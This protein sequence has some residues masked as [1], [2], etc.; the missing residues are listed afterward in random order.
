M[1]DAR[2]LRRARVA[3][4]VGVTAIAFAAI[5]FRRT[6]PT[7]PIVA[8]GLRLVLAS[9]LFAPFAGRSLAKLTPRL[10]RDA[11]LGGLCYALHFGAWVS[12]LA[13]TT[14]AASVTLVTATPLLLALVAF[15]TGKDR[16]TRRQWLAL[17]VAL[18]GTAMLGGSDAFAEGALLGDALAFVGAIA[19][20]GYLLIVRRHGAALPVLA[21]TTVACGVGAL[22]LLGTALALGHSLVPPTNE[23][24]LFVVAATLLPQVVGHT[25][26]TWALRHVPPTTVGLATVAE[27]VGSTVL[28]W[29]WLHEVPGALTLVGCGVTLFAVL[30]SF[31]RK[32]SA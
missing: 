18:L 23:A 32:T 15:A 7:P 31:E 17:P 29:L 6:A 8:A 16:P 28:A 3:V 9:L 30:M 13:L 27:P 10:W 2:S 12:S 1:S 24:A 21:F 22:V 20:A 5:F 14:V 4:A 26:L 11:T 19:M 25:S